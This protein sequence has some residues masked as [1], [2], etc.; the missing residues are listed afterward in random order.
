[1]SAEQEFLQ[2]HIWGLLATGRR[3]GAPQVSMVAYDFDGTNI[4]ISCRSSAAK[5]VN[6]RRNNEVVFSVPDGADN[7]TVGGAAI[8]YETGPERDAFTARLRDTLA[9]DNQWA[10]DKLDADI[11]AGLDTVGRVIIQIAPR[12]MNLIRPRH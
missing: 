4:V 3:N 6:A 12:T 1:M 8:C 9:I 2:A 11:A 10:A 5:Y 7:L